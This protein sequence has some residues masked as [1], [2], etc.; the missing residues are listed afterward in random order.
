VRFDPFTAEAIE[1]PYPQYARLRADE[2]VHWSEKLRS[3]VL[4]RYDDVSAFFRDD[5]RLS[6][7]RSKARRFAGA[8]PA[9]GAGTIRTVATDPPAH[10]PVRAML[11]T[12]L[13]PRVRTVGPRVDALVAALLDRVGAAVEAVV[14]ASTLPPE[15]D[16]VR[17]FAYPLPIN[18]I[19]ELL[20]VP[21]PDRE[22]F[23]GYSK[24]VARGM[25]RFFSGDEAGQGLR[26]IGAYF[27]Q[28]VQERRSTT[29]DDV[30]HRLLG[31]EYQ[32]DRLTELEVIAMCTALVFAGHETTANL[33]GNGMLALLRHL[34]ERERLRADPALIGPA[35]EELLRYDSPAQLISRIAV[36]DFEIHGARIRAGDPVLAA[37]GAANRDPEVFAE[38]D[39]L[40]L[41]RAPNP[42]L[43]FGLGTHACPGAQLTRI[44]ARA[45][46]PALLRRFPG[47]QLGQAPP[48]RRRTAVLR[49]LDELPVRLGP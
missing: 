23:Q 30:V 17:D 31:A 12:S 29:G 2:P 10:V 13:N 25:D 46:I 3:W 6:S 8:T 41:G 14:G 15:V 40:D 21:A 47:L 18:V 26:E 7:D 20:E 33:I 43:A 1:D 24:A 44:E 37:I 48:V 35:V 28:M 34:E 22:H 36:T 45:A 19:A 16:L 27:H 11:T 32:G 5:E 49:G 4:F 38:P 42:H 39:R 9:A